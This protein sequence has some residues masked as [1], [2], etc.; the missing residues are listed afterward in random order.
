[1]TVSKFTT[2]IIFLFLSGVIRAQSSFSPSLNSGC[3]PLLVNFTENHS[4]SIVKRFWD[5]GNNATSTLTNPSTIYTSNGRYTVTL[6]TEDSAG[7]F[8]TITY[9]NI[10]EVF[11][12][13]TALFGTTINRYCVNDTVEIIDKSTTNSNFIKDYLW[14]FGDGIT[15]SVKNPKHA[16]NNAGNYTVTL[17]IVDD[18]GCKSTHRETFFYNIGNLP[19]VNFTTDKTLNCGKPL[20][21]KFIPSINTQIIKSYFWD[22][23]DGKTSTN[24]SP[25]HNYDSIGN[26]TI[27]LTIIDNNNCKNTISKTNLVQNLELKSSF[28]DI[29]SKLCDNESISFKNLSTPK[30]SD[31]RYRWEFGD[32]TT[33]TQ[34]QP[35]KKYTQS[36]NYTIK[37]ISFIPN[38]QCSDT[39]IL[40]KRID[41]I[42]TQNIV[43]IISDTL[44]CKLPNIVSFKPSD[45]ILKAFWRFTNSPFDTS[46]KINPTF[47]FTRVGNFNINY[48]F[49]DTN[50]CVIKGTKVGGV[51]ITSQS[52]SIVGNLIGC[53]PFTETF[54]VQ[55]NNSSNIVKYFWY[56]DDSLVSTNSTF[57]NNFT[58][59]KEGTIKLIVKTKEDCEY[60]TLAKYSYGGK[61]NPDFYP[62]NTQNCFKQN[63]SF[64]VIEDS[65]KYPITRK[66]WIF[67]GLRKDQ[68]QHQFTNFNEQIVTLIA[69]N[70]G[71]PDT[72][73]KIYNVSG[74]KPLLKGP[75]SSIGLDYDFCNRKLIINNK[76]ID[77][78][79]H[80]WNIN[81][82]G[83]PKH[84]NIN[85][86]IFIFD[87]DDSSQ[88]FD[89]TLTTYNDSND[90]KNDTAYLNFKTHSKLFTSFKFEGNVCSPA[91]IQFTNTSNYNSTDTFRWFVNGSQVQK[92]DN[93]EDIVSS[94]VDIDY[95]K[96]QTGNFNPLF[97]F[98]NPG[99]YEIM[100][101]GRRLGCED[102]II[103]TIRTTGPD[104]KPG[105]IKNNN[106]MP[107][108]LTLVDSLFKNNKKAM[109]VIADKDSI[110][111]E[112]QWT[113]YFLQNVPDSGILKIK[114]IEWDENNC[115]TWKV[116]N[117]PIEGPSVDFTFKPLVSCDSAVIEFTPIVQ[118]VGINDKLFYFWDFGDSVTSTKNNV[119]TYRYN[120][121]DTFNVKFIVTD[122]KNCFSII[123]KNVPYFESLLRADF[124]ADTSGVFCPP[125]KVNFKDAT[126]SKIPIKRYF[127][128][129]GDGT[130]S[131]NPN[132]EKMF[133]YPGRYSVKLTV[134]DSLGCIDSI[135]LPD[136][137]VINGP[138]GEFT[139]DKEYG[140]VPLEVHFKLNTND[141][142]NIILW[143]MGDGNLK[144]TDSF[145][146]IYTRPGNFYPMVV[147]KDT[148]GCEFIIPRDRKIT[149]YENP[150]S[151]FTTEGICF[152]DTLFL[153]NKSTIYSNQNYI[154][155]WYLNDSLISNNFDTKN[156][157]DNF[158]N[159]TISLS[160]KSNIGCNDST[161]K[162]IN[163]KPF[164]PDITILNNNICLGDTII[165]LNNSTSK[166]TFKYKWNISNVFTSTEKNIK[167]IPTKSGWYNVE[168]YIENED[169][170]DTI[171]Y[172]EKYAFVRD[173]LPHKNPPILSVSVADDFTV[174]IKHKSSNETEFQSYIVYRQLDN[175]NLK[176]V[177]ETTDR[178]DTFLTETNLN[179]L[180]NVYCYTVVEKNTCEY[181]GN[182]D[183][184]LFHC[185]IDIKGKPDINASIITWNAYYGWDTVERYEIYRKNNKNI[186]F[187]KLAE[188]PG[189]SLSYIDNLINCKSV[190]FYKVKAY[191][192][193]NKETSWSDTCLVEPLYSNIVLPPKFMLSSILE[194]KMVELYWD[195]PLT[196]RSPVS[197]YLLDRSDIIEGFYK[198]FIT[199][200]KNTKFFYDE[201]VDV[202]SFNYF[203]KI[204]I[205]DECDDESEYS[206]Y[207]SP[208]L[209][210][211]KLTEDF[212][213]FLTWTPYK[214][215]DEGVAYYEIEQLIDGI[216]IKIGQ[217]LTGNDTNFLHEDV[218]QNC[219]SPYIYR[220][221]AIKNSSST[222]YARS[223]SNETKLQ[224]KPRLFAP[225]AFSPNNDGLN[226]TYVV[227]GIFIKSINMRIYNRWGEKLY[228]TNECLPTWDGYYMEKMVPD[229]VY[230]VLI[231]AVGADDNIYVFKSSL[232]VI[233]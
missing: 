172:F 116:L 85:N 101:I 197:Y 107:I 205:I 125:F 129:F 67:D 138:T 9:T 79:S 210:K 102:T 202:N 217:T 104:V 70:L 16:Y 209:L 31:I 121:N 100:M 152:N 7:L 43:P 177:R 182:M 23:G 196:L 150:I 135:L 231:Q 10:I 124:I 153:T 154:Y 74:S 105:I 200:D 21:V 35:T 81:W 173:T 219:F 45:T 163:I 53:I 136:F 59:S 62:E 72:I 32:G 147:L 65:T 230:V 29:S 214:K 46:S 86:N 36:G 82:T 151:S 115:V 22:F 192:K 191:N 111:L 176:L 4:K 174:E 145:K 207:T 162:T 3:S 91:E 134:E 106:C 118:N 34:F 194:N 12:N 15:Y 221:I 80:R 188:V 206:E 17:L 98:G 26:F 51:R 128:E 96:G 201:S 19:S 28:E 90:C 193:H 183:D 38:T 140:C 157:I 11:S 220:V 186:D 181:V 18:K 94:S 130:T 149:V 41:I 24:S 83:N 76:S 156:L 37:L 54:R 25:T 184:S 224:V 49:T 58:K 57:T 56:L 95:V 216:F 33:S 170:C 204:K 6:I 123:E 69:Y 48:E 168:L 68:S 178:N 110:I 160:V 99:S 77:Y 131:S 190:Y 233:K 179:T 60:T 189:D 226:D 165:I 30:R 50:N 227:K 117:I 146:H 113:S 169:G 175:N 112:N 103:Q 213:P 148:F 40:N 187:N 144:Y 232:T 127:W 93:D 211:S 203:Y 1:M 225:N 64:L 222:E 223:V 133:I 229:G 195:D 159:K 109:W 13:P 89:I 88:V 119:F 122:D 73:T 27:K 137:I 126:L 39:F 198:S 171:L 208:I 120:K 75:V 61:T 5:F 14:D 142:S 44:F 8:D 212:E 143:D 132:P 66:V 161:N 228:E 47:L 108:N 71:C 78:T 180:H 42:K 63:I 55:T 84:R 97:K 166:D 199:L 164:N 218:I 155:Y 87:L 92:S 20:S 141:S 52:I 167:F 158:G 139:F 114:Y 185:T 215:W 2:V